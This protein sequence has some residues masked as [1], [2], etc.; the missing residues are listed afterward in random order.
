MANTNKFTINNVN[1][2]IED[3]YG[4]TGTAPVFST[5]TTYKI[6]DYV[7][8]NNV[9]YRF[10]SGHSAGAW[11]G[12]DV[13]V[14]NISDGLADVSRLYIPTW[15]GLSDLNISVSDLYSSRHFVFFAPYGTSALNNPV[16]GKG[17]FLMALVFYNGTQCVEVAF[18]QGT[19]GLWMRKYDSSTWTSWT[20]IGP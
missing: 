6:N 18:V 19:I 4:R 8:Y 10:T 20:Q 2:D 16:S 15:D 11:T 12:N 13:S 9:L 1:Y 5:S 17:G 3:T 14:A 7:W